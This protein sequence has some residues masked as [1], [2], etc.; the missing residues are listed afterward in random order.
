MLAGLQN[1]TTAAGPLGPAD[2]QI[3]AALHRA[4]LEEMSYGKC[5][6]ND[7]GCSRST[8]NDEDKSGRSRRLLV[9]GTENRPPPSDNPE[10]AGRHETDEGDGR[11]SN[12]GDNGTRSE[13]NHRAQGENNVAPEQPPW[14]GCRLW[15]GYVGQDQRADEDRQHAEPNRGHARQS[16][17]A[18]RGAPGGC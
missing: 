16:L 18:V 9:P 13:S 17:L 4:Q 11:D 10:H 6:E 8:M 7:G 15:P 14:R 12:I 2:G 1:A 3:R 5:R